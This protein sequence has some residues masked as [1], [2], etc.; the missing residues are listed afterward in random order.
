MSKL[1]E[2]IPQKEILFLL[3]E[4][5]KDEEN[6]EYFEKQKAKTELKLDICRERLEK[7]SEGLTKEQMEDLSM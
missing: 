6:L 5:K 1:I 3:E 2:K 4:I 7:L